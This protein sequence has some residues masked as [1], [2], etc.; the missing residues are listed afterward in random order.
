[1]AGLQS[2]GNTN[3]NRRK[4]CW[5]RLLVKYRFNHFSWLTAALSSLLVMR[6]CFIVIF[7]SIYVH[8]ITI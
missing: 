2:L 3:G 4:Q 6:D 8:F 5:G 1:M 7:K